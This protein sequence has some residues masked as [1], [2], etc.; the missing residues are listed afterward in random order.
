MIRGLRLSGV[1]AAGALL[2]SAGFVGSA[3]VGAA[4]SG[5]YVCSGNATSP[6]VLTGSHGS[7]DVT[8]ICFVD[9]GPAV[10]R[11][12]LTIGGHG[13]L[14]AAFARNDQTGHGTS[15]LTV[16][17]DVSVVHGGTA[18]LG[19]FPTSFACIDDPHQHRPTL[20]SHDVIHGNLVEDDPL[21]VVVHDVSVSGNVTEEGG[22]GGFTCNPKGVFAVFQSPVYSDYE[23][24]TIFGSLSITNLTSCWLGIARVHVH[25]DTTVVNDRLDD[26]D[27]IE[28]LAND[29]DGSLACS[30]DTMTW[31]SG[32]LTNNLFPR[33]LER[34]QVAGAR[35]GQCV[36]ASP[37]HPGG[38]PGPGKF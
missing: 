15:D 13:A 7:V 17:G 4:A 8:G 5:T 1:V 27:A 33:E 12:T 2:G 16:D 29:F 32:D 35:S 11:G 38:K 37:R 30:G 24:S 22:G 23:D 28:I 25:G 10:V 9:A 31:D 3:S 21:G 18:I 19:C 36:L 6:G 34:N 14:L 26:P 20:A